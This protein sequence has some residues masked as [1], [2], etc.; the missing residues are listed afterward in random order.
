M[1]PMIR[2]V[3]PV[4]AALLPVPVA[5]QEASAPPTEAPAQGENWGGNEIV[6]TGRNVREMSEPVVTRQARL[7]SRESDL[8]HTPLATFAEYACP[9]VIGLK[10]DFAEALV[11]RIRLIAGELGVPL[12][13]AG[14]CRPNILVVFTEDGRADLERINKKT[15][16]ISRALSPS[17]RKE[18][19]SDTGPVH[20]FTVTEDRM[21]N[22]QRIPRRQNLVQIPTGTQ[23]GGQ[24]L[25]SNGIRRDITSVTVL[26]D[27]E[28]VDG[29]SLIQLADYAAMRI[30]ARTR[31]AEGEHAPDS[32]LALFDP[33][34][35]APPPG[36]TAFDR[37]FLTTLYEA[38]PYTDGQGNLQRVASTLRKQ[39]GAEE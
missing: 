28:R 30:F 36:L 27:I 9:G 10:R 33:G 15:K 13:E 29:F 35:E 23:E 11:G 38:G 25:I 24:S 21:R 31:D 1:V 2:H 4:L 16:E 17:E 14:N 39:V 7:V 32:I 19:L 26:Y 3:L 34:N 18:L 5:A 20:V 6:V 12:W 22:G 8:R 37:A